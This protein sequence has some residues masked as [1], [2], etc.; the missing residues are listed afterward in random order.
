MRLG[1][2][3]GAPENKMK[4]SSYPPTTFIKDIPQKATNLLSFE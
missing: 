3:D 1:D 2:R 4:Y